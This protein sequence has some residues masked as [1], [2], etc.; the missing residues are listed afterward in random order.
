M[1]HAV[2]SYIYILAVSQSL[3]S[4]GIAEVMRSRAVVDVDVLGFR[5]YFIRLDR[6][7]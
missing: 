2:D 1:R 3:Q 4:V 5:Y 6:S 7:A